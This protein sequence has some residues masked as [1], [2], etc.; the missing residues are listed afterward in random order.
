[1]NR[2]FSDNKAK[3]WVATVQ[4][5]T[6]DS[7]LV[8][9]M[10]DGQGIT[11]DICLSNLAL[12]FRQARIIKAGCSVGDDVNR[13]RKTFEHS[14]S[15]FAALLELGTIPVPNKERHENSGLSELVAHLFGLKM[16]D[17]QPREGGWGNLPLSK[18]QIIYA[19][20]DA[21]A[22]SAI[23][24]HVA[25][26]E[27]EVYGIEKLVEKFEQGQMLFQDVLEVKGE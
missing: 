1:V 12:V 4:L 2:N 23:A 22:G 21:W 9:Q 18:E 3:Y 5:A 11:S 25:T 20:R 16:L 19:A 6:E 27:P 17:N 24:N 10:V 26:R 8:V 13:L 14:M 15:S 7:A